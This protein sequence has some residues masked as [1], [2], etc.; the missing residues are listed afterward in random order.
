METLNFAF[1]DKKIRKGIL[2]TL[3]MLLL[4]RIGVNVPVFGID[5]SVLSYLYE[6]NQGLFDIYSILSG[7]SFKDMT[8]FSMGV[9]PYITGSIV[10]Q[11][12]GI[13]Y[14]GIMNM[15]RDDK[16]RYER[17]TI[18][19]GIVLAF[20][21]AVGITFGMF[22][23]AVIGGG[24]LMM[25]LVI[26][27]LVIGAS[28]LIL[29]GKAIDEKGIGNGISLILFTG[30]VSRLVSSGISIYTRV[31]EG[32]LSYIGLGLFLLLA[33]LMVLGI[34]YVQEGVRKVPVNYA[35]RVEGLKKY[36]GQK[37]FIPIKVNP[38]GVLPIIFALTVIQFPVTIS[39]FFPGSRYTEILNKYLSVSSSLGFYIYLLL[40][41][42]LIFFFSY[43]YSEISFN[44]VE[45]A[46]NLRRSGG[47][48]I[49]TR[50]GRDTVEKLSRVSKRLCIFGAIFLTIV[51]TTPLLVTHFGNMNVSLGGT[52]M[53]IAVGV[54][55]DLM[56]KLKEQ[57]LLKKEYHF[58]V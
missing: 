19:L 41:V 9:S 12:L 49:G 50:P 10:I 57:V 44:P 7:G 47:T 24:F 20:L 6:D 14:P 37:T 8:F 51:A 5:R 28:L 18:I 46:N 45:I 54:A 23:K 29:I 32:A 17:I 13:A 11:L 25:A 4:Y 31:L 53:I 52:S 33:L 3:L 30:I 38:N 56:E 34:V 55:I 40:D 36:R 35:G 48:L 21:Q 39:Y 22:R 43:F 58:L 27:Q 16:K 2:F 15:A 42:A 1:K 26:T